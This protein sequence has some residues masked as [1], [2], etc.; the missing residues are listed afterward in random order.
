M[1]NFGEVLLRDDDFFEALKPDTFYILSDYYVWR[2][3]GVL[4]YEFHTGHA[5]ELRKF[6]QS[7]QNI[8]QGFVGDIGKVDIIRSLEN[9]VQEV[10]EEV[11]FLVA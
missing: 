3:E 4:H 9:F 7:H 10:A 2:I 8:L 11:D 1:M 5:D 6:K